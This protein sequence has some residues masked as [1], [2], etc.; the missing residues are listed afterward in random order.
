LTFGLGS[1]LKLRYPKIKPLIILA[2]SLNIWKELS[3]ERVRG[4]ME[5]VFGN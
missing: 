1:V 5:R 2:K 3:L 4:E